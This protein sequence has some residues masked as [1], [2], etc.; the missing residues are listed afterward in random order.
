MSGGKLPEAS[1]H[2]RGTTCVARSPTTSSVLTHLLTSY[3]LGSTTCAARSPTIS[4]TR[5]CRRTCGSPRC[6]RCRR[7]RSG[8]VSPS[9]R[10]G[11]RGPNRRRESPPH[12]PPRELA[13]SCLFRG[14]LVD[15]CVCACECM[16]EGV[17]AAWA[18][19]HD[20]WWCVLKC[21]CSTSSM[22]V[23]REVRDAGQGGKYVTKGCWATRCNMDV[24]ATRRHGPCARGFTAIGHDS[25]AS[26]PWVANGKS[27]SKCMA[28]LIIGVPL[29]Q[30]IRNECIFI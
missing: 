1:L 24:R 11:C 3:P 10:R 12:L 26:C 29:T 14:R 30:Y 4:S 22:R 5:M 9:R 8:G 18:L 17:V 25:W 7:G 27:K 16:V 2:A 23:V 28:F 19:I 20:R 15:M 13:L 21:V 6:A